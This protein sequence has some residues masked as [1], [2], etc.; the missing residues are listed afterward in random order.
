MKGWYTAVSDRPPKPCHD[1]MDKQI[2][3]REELYWK[4]SSPGDPIPIN[5]EPF[6]LNDS[7]RRV[8]QGSGGRFV[9]RQS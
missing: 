3:E 7:I 5:V 1:S 9:K 2:A 8:N 4:V 6:D